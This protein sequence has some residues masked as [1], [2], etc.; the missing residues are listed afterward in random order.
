MKNRRKYF[1][2]GL[3]LIVLN[4]FCEVKAGSYEDFFTA[5]RRDHRNN[6]EELLKRGFDPNTVDEQGQPGL[7]LALKLES[8][9]VSASPIARAACAPTRLPS[10]IH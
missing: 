3:Y 6:I 4:G 1:Q 5:I 9:K 10:S 8:F 7:I 2:L